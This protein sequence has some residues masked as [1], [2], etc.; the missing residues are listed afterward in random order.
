MLSPSPLP[1][2]LLLLLLLPL[3]LITPAEPIF[4]DKGKDKNIKKPIEV[5]DKNIGLLLLPLPVHFISV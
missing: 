1:L 5:E 3:S 2:L 4:A